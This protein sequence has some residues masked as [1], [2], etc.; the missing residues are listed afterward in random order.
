MNYV[1]VVRGENDYWLLIILPYANLPIVFDQSWNRSMTIGEELIEECLT[2]LG[3]LL[4]FIELENWDDPRRRQ[5]VIS[6]QNLTQIEKLTSPL[7]L[8]SRSKTQLLSRYRLH[9]KVVLTGFVPVI[10]DV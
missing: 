10:E 6:L 9:H 5:I 1:L 3:Q 4:K 7:L 8:T 2:D